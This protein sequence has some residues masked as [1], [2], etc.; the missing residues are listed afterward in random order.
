[1]MVSKYNTITSNANPAAVS[2]QKQMGVSSITNTKYT[3][4]YI[5]KYDISVR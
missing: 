2:V 5:A 3:I 4:N 1:M